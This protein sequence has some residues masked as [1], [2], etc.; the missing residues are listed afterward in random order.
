MLIA[1]AGTSSTATSVERARWISE[2]GVDGLLVVS[3]AYVR[4]TQEGLFLHFAAIAANS[5]VPV[6]LYNVPGRTA[7]DLLPATVAR[8]SRV[9]RIVGHQGSGGRDGAG[10]RA[11][12]AAA[13]RTS[14]L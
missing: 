2:L 5:R 4:P 7:V 12:R 10:A 9:P 3:P 14:G 1:N 11:G 13:P 6:L 8:L